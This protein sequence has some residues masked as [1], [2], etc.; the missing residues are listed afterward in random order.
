MES[1]LVPFYLPLNSANLVNLKG[2]GKRDCT[3]SGNF[4]R[5]LAL[6]SFSCLLGVKWS[7]WSNLYACVSTLRENSLRNNILNPYK[8]RDSRIT[9]ST[10][11]NS[12][13]RG[14]SKPDILAECAF[15]IIFHATP[16]LL[17][18]VCSK[19]TTLPQNAR[20]FFPPLIQKD[21][22]SCRQ[23]HGHKQINSFHHIISSLSHQMY[24]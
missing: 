14:T 24:F 9:F 20:T 6:K 8:S 4:M 11:D 23:Q 2:K 10:A 7:L 19:M 3:F 22:S 15:Y 17:T 18:P 13:D 21:F 1:K 5:R 16:Q 12:E